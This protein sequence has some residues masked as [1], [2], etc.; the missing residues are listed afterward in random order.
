MIIIGYPKHYNMYCLNNTKK[1]HTYI[2]NNIKFN[3]IMYYIY[4]YIFRTSYTGFIYINL[5]KIDL[6]NFDFFILYNLGIFKMW[7]FN[8]IYCLIHCT[9]RNVLHYFTDWTL[10]IN[11]S[12]ENF[13]FKKATDAIYWLL[14][15]NILCIVYTILNH[16][17]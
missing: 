3:S 16:S 9:M 2:S 11:D 4:I 5:K 15:F 6:L 7:K 17:S 13:E 8:V 12:V 14:Y 1:V 10:M